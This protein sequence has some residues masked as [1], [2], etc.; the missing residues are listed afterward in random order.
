MPETYTVQLSFRSEEAHGCDLLAE[1]A[2]DILDW[3][4]R[5]EVILSDPFPHYGNWQMPTRGTFQIDGATAGY[6]EWWR[7]AWIQPDPRGM[8][9]DWFTSA[10]LATLGDDV[11]CRLRIRINAREGFVTGENPPVNPPRIVPRLVEKPNLTATCLGEPVYGTPTPL[12]GPR[13][14]AF[15]TNRLED[16][17]RRLPIVMVSVGQTGRPL[18]DDHRLAGQLSG[19]A[20]VVSLDDG[21]ASWELTRQVGQDFSCFNGAVRI[22]WPGLNTRRDNPFDH[23]LWVPDRITEQRPQDF[24]QGLFDHLCLRV[25][26]ALGE[27]PVWHEVHRKIQEHREED[28]RQKLIQLSEDKD[29]TEK[30]LAIV[31]AGKKE[32]E[33]GKKE[34]ESDR[35]DAWEWADNLDKQLRKAERER[36]DLQNQKDQLKIALAAAQISQAG[37]SD[38]DPEI[39]S[40][41]DA[42]KNASSFPNLQFCSTALDSASESQSNRGNDL[43]KIFKVLNLLATEYRNGLGG[44][45]GDWIGERVPDVAF[46][47][48][49]HISDTTA[50]RNEQDYTFDGILMPKH[51]KFGGGHNTPNQVRVHFEF[52]F[53]DGPPRCV[54]GWC[55]KHLPNTQT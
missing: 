36:D 26:R 19:L 55:G 13:V 25:G 14:G 15:V 44:S 49:H 24:Q 4:Q 3:A 39:S 6:G 46:D 51:L 41:L 32:A 53:R 43:Y 21:E 34:A 37:T 28:S 22:Y 1:I 54:I 2:T 8:Q 47:Y 38:S 45:V 50:S 35:D 7:L 31:E 11:E 9:I 40:V 27:S 23:R 30:I 12:T 5:G 10:R 33:A 29:I 42:V 16:A 48:A 18:V 17:G 52:E 20:E